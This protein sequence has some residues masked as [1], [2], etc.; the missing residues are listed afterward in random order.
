LVSWRFVPQDGEKQLSKAE[1]TSEP[2]DFLEKALIDRIRR[3]P[4][5]WDMLPTIGEP[6]DPENDPTILWPK[7]RKELKVGTLTLSSAMNQTGAACEKINYSSYAVS[8][9]KRLQGK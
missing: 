1:L 8:F 7:E 2:T 4:V 6:G 9:A 3:G 5:R